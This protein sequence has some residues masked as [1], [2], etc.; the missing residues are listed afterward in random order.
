MKLNVTKLLLPKFYGLLKIHKSDVP[1]K[2]VV[3]NLFGIVA[4][5]VFFKTLHGPLLYGPPLLHHSSV[6]LHLKNKVSTFESALF[7]Q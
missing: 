1:L 4:H 3:F 2:P 5:F 7:A 6:A